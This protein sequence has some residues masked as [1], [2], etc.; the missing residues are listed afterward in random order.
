MRRTRAKQGEL[1][2]RNLGGPRKGSGRKPKGDRPLVSHDR[3][4]AL[5]SRNPV[6][7]TCK[8]RRGLPTL[9]RKAEYRVLRGAFAKGCERFGFRLVHYSVQGD[10]LHLIAEAKDRRAL[11]RGMQ[12]LLVRVAKGLNKLWSRKG[13]V[14][15]DHY[16]DRILRTPR[17][18]RNAL[19]YVM[20]NAR[21]HGRHVT[22]G[23]DHFCSGW[24]FD[25][26]REELTIRGLDGVER[27]VAHARTWLLDK[28]WRKHRLL[29]LSEVPG[30]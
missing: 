8:L 13:S 6:H 30:G 29:S 9:R 25:G 16:H 3:R 21:K 23:L 28:G 2:Y 14:F 10:H 11:S 24:W 7:V 22:K 20:H 12:G 4:A 26:W 1:P 27:P 18:V 5:A 17:E 19:A 15:G